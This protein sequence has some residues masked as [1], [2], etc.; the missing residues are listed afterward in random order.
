MK[1]LKSTP[2]RAAV[3]VALLIAGLFGGAGIAVAQEPTADQQSAI[4]SNC[5]SDSWRIVPVC[6]EAGKKRC[7]V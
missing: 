7:N 1:A 2:R 6:R 3:C 5:R 4:R